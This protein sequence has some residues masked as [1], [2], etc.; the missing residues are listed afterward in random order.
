M[1]MTA[2]GMV[3]KIKAARANLPS[4]DGTPAQA[5]TQSDAMLLALCQGIL[6]EITDNSELVP[7]ATDSGPAGAG[8]I[9]GKVA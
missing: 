5:A 9:S 4:S 3:E 7:T 1:A 6:G 2:A 8:I